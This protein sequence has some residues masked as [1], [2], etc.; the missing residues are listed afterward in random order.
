MIE[1]DDKFEYE[2]AFSFLQQDESLAYEIN[3]LIQDRF[4]TFIYSEHQKELAGTDGERTFNK[5]FCEKT[6]FVVVLYRDD[7]GKTNWTRIEETAIRNRGHEEGYDFTIFVQ[8]DPNSKMPIWLPKT[9]IYFNLKRWGA[10][11]LAP[12]IEAKIQELG[13]QNRA[14][15]LEDQA[16]KIK[17][18]I[19]REKERN[20]YLDSPV[21]YTDAQL[22]FIKL[23]QLL[24]EKTKALE[25]I[26]NSFNFGYEKLLQ[27]KF[28]IHCDHYSANFSWYCAYNNSLTNS[29][30]YV[31][32]TSYDR[33]NPQSFLKR[34]ISSDTI[35]DMVIKKQNYN[36]DINIVLNEKGWS[37]KTNK[38]EFY[39]S[40]QIMVEWLRL[41]LNKVK[42]SK[43]KRERD[44]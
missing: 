21:A 5:V 15:T 13:G 33:N 22:E 31:S 29:K 39:T 43:L 42:E 30:L 40:E 32:I 38:D 6:R 16:A 25:G 10:K 41:F 28:I 27:S 14:E 2:V 34:Q 17:R 7:W 20:L 12:V 35:D 4:K 23:Y 1:I 8:V 37:N 19:Q 36:F 11:G 9:R 24:E 18:A 44:R 3:D 26:D